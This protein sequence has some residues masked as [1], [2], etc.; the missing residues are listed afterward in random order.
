[1]DVADLITRS[2]ERFR[3]QAAEQEVSL[4]TDL[5][6]DLPTIRGDRQ[7]IGQVLSNLLSNALR[8]TPA[9]GQVVMAA[10]LESAELLISVADTGKGI[11]PDD[12]PY[13]FERFY[14]ADKSRARASGGSGLGLAI[15]RQIIEAHGSRI[16]AESQVGEG[17]TFFVALPSSRQG[18][19]AVPL[20]EIERG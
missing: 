15:A 2:L 16:W 20:A 7:R 1:V 6:T 4:A 5:P 19:T 9:G 11:P 10:K 13:V 18:L 17:A 14:R 3:A 12:L 8:Y